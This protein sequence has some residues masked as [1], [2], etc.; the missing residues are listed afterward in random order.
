MFL[1]WLDIIF[2][3]G[4]IFRWFSKLWNSLDDRTKKEIIEAIVKAFEEVTRAFYKWWKS[5]ENENE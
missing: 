5:R 1:N 4:W 3:F 2:P